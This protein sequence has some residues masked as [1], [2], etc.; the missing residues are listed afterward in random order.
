MSAPYIQASVQPENSKASYG[1]YDNVDFVATFENRKLVLNSVRLEG[2]I[3]VTQGGANL[4]GE[5]VYMDPNIGIHSVVDTVQ[6][7]F[8]TKGSVENLSGYARLVGMT[9]DAT[10][11]NLDMMNSENTSELKMPM[12]EMMPLILEGEKD[13]VTGSTL[14]DANS[15]SFKPQFVL[16]TASEVNNGGITMSYNKSGAIRVTFTLA[17]TAN[18]LYGAV[19]AN[20]SYSV[21]NLRLVYITV[22]EDNMKNET[23][24]KV[25]YHI[26]QSVLSSRTNVSSKVPAVVSGVSCSFI[27]QS[28][29][30]AFFDNTNE[31]EVFPELE[32]L[33][34]LF[35][36]N[37]NEYI[38]YTINDRE[39]ILSRY[40]ESMKDTKHSN[41]ELNALKGGSS[42]GVG[43]H[44]GGELINL[45]NQTFNVVLNSGANISTSPYS[46]HLYFHSQIVV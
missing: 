22:P 8:Q 10:T 30:N 6:T 13:G 16:N 12:K 14:N 18:V 41:M 36:N 3:R 19:D 24:H 37:T 44:F 27:E 4:T 15:F 32:E 20:T 43:L 25:K 28:K 23:A 2:D 17:R 7:S 39:E 38:S 46:L 42:Y 34:F 9:E 29:E 40:I 35:N 45:A 11:S 5:L 26:K 33:N 21:S 1:E 31:R